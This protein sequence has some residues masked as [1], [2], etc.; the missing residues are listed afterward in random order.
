MLEILGFQPNSDQQVPLFTMSVSAGSPVPVDN[1][2]DSQ[3]DLNEYLVEHPAAT[4]FAKVVGE[5][6]EEAGIKDGDILIVDAS[7]QP[8]DG[9][10]VV[11]SICGDLA[12]RYYRDIDDEIFLESQNQQF[13]PIDI[14]FYID[15]QVLG[16][17]TRIIH[18]L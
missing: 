10:I 5:E 7:A 14:G 4:F 3:I 18:S 9:S 17:V 16:T 6:M 1:D 8:E 11:A 15:Y 13:I 12:I 2:I